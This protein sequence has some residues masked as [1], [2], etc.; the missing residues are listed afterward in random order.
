MRIQ[1]S[2]SVADGWQSIQSKF[3]ISMQMKPTVGKVFKVA[4]A[5]FALL[6]ISNVPTAHAGPVLEVACMAACTG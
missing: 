6:A 2:M 1:S 3:G 5:S 4:L